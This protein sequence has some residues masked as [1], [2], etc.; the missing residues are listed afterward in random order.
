MLASMTDNPEFLV[1]LHNTISFFQVTMG[2][3]V[4]RFGCRDLEFSSA[5]SQKTKEKDRG[6]S[7]S[8]VHGDTHQVHLFSFGQHLVSLQDS[9]HK[10]F[11][12]GEH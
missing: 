9:L 1:T 3:R 8:W 5:T 10:E 4:V 11:T 12:D 7:K 2:G 6:E